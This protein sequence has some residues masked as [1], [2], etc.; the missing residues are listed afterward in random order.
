[1]EKENKVNKEK[2]KKERF[3]KAIAIRTKNIINK[4]I[5][6]GAL[7]NKQTYTWDLKKVEESFQY[8]YDELEHQRKRFY[9]NI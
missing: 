7:S 8:I 1:M 3:N 2:I 4:I 9:V 6:F 5:V